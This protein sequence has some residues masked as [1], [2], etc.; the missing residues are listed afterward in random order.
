[1]KTCSNSTV[2]RGLFFILLWA[3][4]WTATI[5]RAAVALTLNPSTIS[6]TYSSSISLQITGLTNGET[7]L[8]ERFIDANSNA[9]VDSG[10]L[11]V[12]SFK[13]TDGQVT[14]FGGIRNTNIPGDE[15]S[16]TNGQI[17]TF[18]TFANWPEFS[19]GAG[20]HLFR[21]SS[22]TGRFS[23]VTNLLAV[24]Q[25]AYPQR[26][27]GQVTSGGSPVTNAL[28]ALLVTVGTDV[29]FV[30]GALADTTGNFSL[31]APPG[32]YLL[33]AAKSGLVSD[34]STAP[35]ITLNS[36]KVV[37]QSLTLTAPTRTI[38]G[39]VSDASTT[40]GIPG[41]QLFFQ[42]N[43]GQL[44]FA[45]SDSAGNFNASVVASQW[46][47]DVSDFSIGQ[48][49]YLR[50]QNK[51]KPDSTA[52]N[53][54]GVNIQLPKETALIYGNLRNDTNAPLAGISFRG[55]DNLNQYESPA[56]TDAN[57]N[58]AMGVIAGDWFIEPD[59]QNPALAGYLVQ[60]T[61]VTV[62]ASQAVAVNFVARR[63]TAHFLG[64]VIDSG[65]APV[66]DLQILA[67][68]QNGGSA[69]SATTAADGSFDIAV[70]GGTWN[71]Q[72]ETSSAAQRN[73][74]GPML[75]YDITD[76]MNI[77]NITYVVRSVAAQI[78]GNVHD[79]NSNPIAFVNLSAGITVNGTNY[80]T[81]GQTDG[82]GNYS[83][84]VFNG[85]WSVGIFDND[86][87]SRGFETPA[88]Q[89]ATVSGGNVSVNFTIYPIQPLQITTTNLPTGSVSRNYHTNLQ[90]TGGQ[91]P[92]NWS[93]VSGSLP[94]GVSFNS[95]L[96]DGIPTN[97]GT[98]SFTVQVSDQQART[99][100]KTLSITI[101]PAL[102]ITTGSLPPGTNNVFYSANLTASGGVQPYT[103]QV[104]GS[105][106]AGLNLNTNTG[107]I[108]GTPTG[109]GTN[110]FTVLVNDSN[111]GN[112]TKNLSIAINSTASNPAP[113]FLSLGKNGNGNFE[114][115]IQGVVGRSYRFEGS[116]TL[117][118]NSWTTLQTSSANPSDGKVYFQDNNSPS[119][120]A[121]FYRAVLLP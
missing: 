81:Y 13:V 74:I 1:M 14:K 56:I 100:N 72:L 55:N 20:N 11:L 43:S 120:S 21:V 98:F 63:S 89:N 77:S 111:G 90:A 119:F 114:M 3:E 42:S 121:R 112:T 75:T 26:V 15:D 101:N 69:P 86:L 44:A 2:R 67:V 87:S 52:G 96:I 7:V 36:S 91:Q 46:K 105:L 103:W 83:L 23:A 116:T 50:L 95:G 25:A 58:Y 8:L 47:I 39:Q 108:S 115:L 29:R 61:N 10:E 70:F 66:S 73:L 51:A 35:M 104:G 37:T 99:T 80:S 97:S 4:L 65:G 84:G 88:N 33:L 22:P 85:T 79:T 76:G 41:V 28:V 16:A 53:V 12:Q 27:T 60:G 19:R 82:S 57:G 113:Y 117:A 31:N 40:A 93:L 71:L 38:S 102:Q 118:S 9:A 94:P 62:A 78:N 30:L 48:L 18:F 49:G 64:R 110:F 45:F 32:D 106:P 34:F 5:S 6:N 107:A 17:T 24:T 54:P 109:S 59:N 68:P 92:Y